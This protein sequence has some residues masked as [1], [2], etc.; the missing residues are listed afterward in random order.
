MKLEELRE[1]IAKWEDL[2]TDFKER[3]DSNLELAKDLVC[4][5]NTDGGQLIF[6]ISN[7][8]NIVGIDDPDRLFSE[9]DDVAFQ[10]CEPSITVIQESLVVDGR[11]VVVV[12]IPKGDQRP[13]RTNTG[14]YYIRATSGCRQAS[15]EELRRLFQSTESLYYD[16]TPLP[17]L[18]LSDVDFAAFEN[19]LDE[20]G[21][22]DL[23]VD[24]ERSM[25]NWR[26]L[27]GDHPT[28]AGTI[29]FGRK[30]QQHLPYAQV[31]AARIPGDDVSIEPLDMKDITGRL[32]EVVDLVQRFLRLHLPVKHEIKGFSPEAKSEL[33]E[34]ALREAVM[35]AVAHRDYTVQGPI[36]IFILDDRLEIH[37]PGRVPNTVD[38]AAMRAGVHVVRNPHIYARLSDAGLV[39]RPGSGIR[40]IIRLI[41]EATGKDI[42]IDLRDF[43]VLL[44][45]PRKKSPR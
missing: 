27:S 29:L 18:S 31:N 40:R 28:L 15:R 13:Y 16:E 2:H 44:T 25:R 26:L 17:R 43:E 39:T 21:Q 45:I 7:D 30:P 12:N 42:G 14:L 23:G 24:P 41:N 19:F 22:S 3:F 35:N 8:K 36:R 5:A 6:G 32:L 20:T 4:F 34:E 10:H 38:E 9:V 33:P 37:T 11:T 1:R